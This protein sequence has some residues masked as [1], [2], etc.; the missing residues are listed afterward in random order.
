MNSIFFRAVESAKM[1]T[2]VVIS[3]AT[4]K[5]IEEIVDFKESESKSTPYSH[6]ESRK[7]EKESLLRYLSSVT[8]DVLVS[9]INRKIVGTCI[10]IV[11]DVKQSAKKELYIGKLIV[12]SRC[13]GKGIGTL[14]IERC[15]ADSVSK[16]IDLVTLAVDTD[17]KRAISLYRRLGFES[18]GEYLQYHKKEVCIMS[19]RV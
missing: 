6:F 14:M 11:R 3:K 13:R 9:R 10:T 18:T 15:I 16:G 17:N 8:I 2:N 5:D 4:D 19:L 12:S 7:D 1:M